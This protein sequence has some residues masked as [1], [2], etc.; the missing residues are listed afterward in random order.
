MQR[1]LTESLLTPS[2]FILVWM[3]LSYLQSVPSWALC[4][5]SALVCQ[6]EI[7]G[8]PVF[9]LGIV[10][11]RKNSSSLRGIDLDSNCCS[12]LETLKA[13]RCYP[14]SLIPKLSF[15]AVELYIWLLKLWI[16]FFFNGTFNI[17]IYWGVETSEALKSCLIP[18]HG[19]PNFFTVLVST[20]Q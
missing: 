19:S 5:V 12:A 7:Q 8:L 20:P 6:L 10:V 11:P 1:A 2:L 15:I 16:L 13:S 3:W 4:A 9:V 17:S 14:V 18:S